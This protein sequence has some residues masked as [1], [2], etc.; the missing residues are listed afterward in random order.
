M[1]SS[2]ERYHCICTYVGVHLKCVCTLQVL[3][4]TKARPDFAVNILHSTHVPSRLSLYAC[5]G[6]QDVSHTH[7]MAFMCMYCGALAVICTYIR[8]YITV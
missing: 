2:I 7:L 6:A 8:M 4:L 5:I 3:S 1:V